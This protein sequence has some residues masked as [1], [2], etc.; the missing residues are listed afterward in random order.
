MIQS[1][2]DITQQV[3]STADSWKLEN[4]AALR[5]VPLRRCYALREAQ[6]WAA[7]GQSVIDIY[8]L[9][10]IFHLAVDEWHESC[11]VATRYN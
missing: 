4:N 10:N 6:Y 7:A 3:K 8:E 9:K 1:E 11:A 2:T 5:V